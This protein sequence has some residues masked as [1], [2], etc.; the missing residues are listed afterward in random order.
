MS[1]LDS[2]RIHF[3]GWFQA[4]VSTI[5][6]DVR[7]FQNDS[8]VPDYQQLN[9]NGSW[10]PQGT[11]VFRILDC[12][13]TG[14]FLN[15]RALTSSSDDAVI[16]LTLQNADDRAPGKLVD[17]DPQQ[18]MVS[19]I[20]GMYVRLA[21]PKAE[22]L[23]KGEYKPA[24]FT[25]L[26]KR[27]QTGPKTDQQLCAS[28][29]SVLENVVWSGQIDSPLLTALK[30]A[31]QEQMLSIQFNLYGYGRDPSMPRY[32][33]GHLVGTIGPYRS[34][35]PKHFALGRQMIAYASKSPFLPD[36]KV[37]TLQAQVAADGRS[38]TIDFGNSFPIHDANG[39]P[40]NIG[41]VLLGVLRTNPPGHI[42]TVDASE[43]V[44]IGEVP[45]LDETWY[46]Q[47]AAVQTFDLTQNTAAQQLL[48]NNPLVLMIPPLLGAATYNVLLQE[49]INGVYVRADSFV[50][51]M[52]PEEADRVE[53]Y[54]T[55]FG[56]PLASSDINLSPTEGFM[57]GSG[58]GDAVSPTPRPAAAVP[59]IGTPADALNFATSISTDADGRAVLCLTAS[60]TGPGN[61][62][63]YIAGQLYGIAYQ[64][65][66]Q[67]P[68]YISNPLNYL[69][70]L[71]FD[72]KVVPDK[73]TW[74]QDIQQLFTQYGNLY[75]IMS[76]YVVDLSDYNA[77]AARIP[78]L[79]L[80]F[81]LPMRDSNHMPVTRDLGA[82]DRAT[83]LKWLN[84]RGPD[85]KPLLGSPPL[86][87]PSAEHV[88]FAAA[89]PQ[90]A[91]VEAEPLQGA[92]KTIFIRQYEA[93]LRAKLGRE[94]G[95]EE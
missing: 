85:G 68:G 36:S 56:Q 46:T 67:P 4:D 16:G 23:F 13:V 27:Q 2:P 73:P 39:G 12:S 22:E 80:A 24:A 14:G 93:R 19:Q 7:F 53:F 69:S 60:D 50:Y 17:L 42:A 18:Q 78:I 74:Y 57:G 28:Y 45:Y 35:E 65:A 84:S 77:V 90:A 40:E 89:S 21:G 86:S 94:G 15:G 63:G 11:G 87:S 20:W 49:S 95:S 66:D 26:W 48:S 88:A 81:S 58:G 71:V 34:G 3:R 29:Q 30:A 25:D 62:R 55:R 91:G 72:K 51:R 38:L 9:S 31:M 76:R 47:T 75:P 92:G 70:V 44:L 41:Q 6:N 5:N 83:I 1:Y 10:N 61:P 43:V 59:D 82:G 8:F 33:M 64:L 79:K 32:T 52:N 54:A 37:N